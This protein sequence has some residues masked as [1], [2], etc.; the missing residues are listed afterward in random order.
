MGKIVEIL[1][2]IIN[3]IFD[4]VIELVRF[5]TH[6]LFIL[7]IIII[8]ILIIKYHKPINN[9]FRKIKS[10]LGGIFDFGDGIFKGYKENIKSKNKIDF[11]I[12][13]NLEKIILMND[14]SV[15]KY[16]YASIATIYEDET[17]ES[18]TSDI[19]EIKKNLPSKI[20]YKIKYKG[21]VSIGFDASKLNTTID[22]FHKLILVKIPELNKIEPHVDI[23]SIETIYYNYETK[24]NASADFIN[25]A[26]KECIE[27]MRYKIYNDEEIMNM[28]RVN[29]KNS[30]MSIIIPFTKNKYLLKVE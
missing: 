27:D 14:L 24:Y 20:L 6:N 18:E 7:P 9:V 29:A 28:A 21:Y 5:L 12:V 23:D 10:F 1:S 13:S 19:E 3:K 17:K 26:Y 16:P 30:I 25:T 22:K 4:L 11:N 2:N 8:I 15:M